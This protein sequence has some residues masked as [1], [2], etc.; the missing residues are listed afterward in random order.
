MTN[1]YLSIIPSD[2]FG[3]FFFL[4]EEK[5]SGKISLFGVYAGEA[6]SAF[7]TVC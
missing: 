5:T 7:V 6:N 2:D 4:I 3:V 1:M